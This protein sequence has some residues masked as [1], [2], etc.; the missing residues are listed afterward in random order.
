MLGRLLGEFDGTVVVVAVVSVS[1]LALLTLVVVRSALHSTQT[2]EA[3]QGVVGKSVRGTACPG[4]LVLA[5]RSPIRWPAVQRDT[6]ISSLCGPGLCLLRLE[7]RAASGWRDAFS[8][9]LNDQV[10]DC[11]R[12]R[13]GLPLVPRSCFS[14]GC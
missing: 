8:R 9:D 11:V 2:C 14:C 13:P 1:W 4:A 6:T 7:A 5:C 10:L 3:R 12:R